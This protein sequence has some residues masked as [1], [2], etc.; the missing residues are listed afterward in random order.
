MGYAA[1]RLASSRAAIPS[2]SREIPVI[3]R[4]TPTSVPIA[5]TELDGQCNRIKPPRNNV[6]RPLTASIRSH[7]RSE[8]GEYAMN[9]STV[10]IRIMTASR[11]VS[12][13]SPAMDV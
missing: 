6:I 13:P 12:V 9:S 4:F 8:A 1:A 2:M 11:S 10:S 3:S 5:H 7:L